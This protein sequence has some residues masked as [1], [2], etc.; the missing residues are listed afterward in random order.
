M[1]STTDLWFAAF[2]MLRKRIAPDSWER[3]D[4]GHIRYFYELTEEEWADYKKECITDD[5]TDIKYVI[6]R[7]KDLSF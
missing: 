6:E 2:L 7:L 4:R 3:L 5:I 1:K